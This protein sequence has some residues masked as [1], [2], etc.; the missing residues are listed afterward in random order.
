M[1][2]NRTGADGPDKILKVPVGTQ[3]FAED[4]KTLIGDL[5]EIGDE[6]VLAKGGNGG[7]GNARFKGPVNQSPVMQIRVNPDGKLDMVAHETHCGCR[8][9]WSS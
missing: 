8:S 1:G 7:F 9:G 2:K 5:T 4:G 3:I 6:I